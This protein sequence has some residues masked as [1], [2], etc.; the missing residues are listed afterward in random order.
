MNLIV[1]NEPARVQARYLEDALQEL[2]HA[3]RHVATAVNGTFV[4]VGE[5]KGH[6]LHEGDRLEILAP[7]QGG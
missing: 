7:M 1:N 3:G 6:A 4:P 2:G 5:R